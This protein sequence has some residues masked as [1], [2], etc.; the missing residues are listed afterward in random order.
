MAMLPMSKNLQE[1]SK[2]LHDLEEEVRNSTLKDA[3][4]ATLAQS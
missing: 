3:I 2:G 1:L 4:D